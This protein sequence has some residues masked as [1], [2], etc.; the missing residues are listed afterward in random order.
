AAHHKGM[1][2]LKSGPGHYPVGVNI[3][4]QDEQAVGPASQR[5]EHRRY[6]YAAWFDAANKSDF[7][8]VQVYTRWRF[9]KDGMMEPEPGVELTQS[10]YEF[11]PE[12]LEAAIRYAHSQVRVPIYVTENGVATEDDTRRV[13]YIRRAVGGLGHCLAD[14]IDVR[15]YLHW[16]LLDNFE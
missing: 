7:I 13:E 3:A 6:L 5:D 11:W 16:S 2:A 14:G 8:G 15:G 9:D 12:A 10:G 4:L 1:A